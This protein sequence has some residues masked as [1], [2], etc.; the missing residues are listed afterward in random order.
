VHINHGHLRHPQDGTDPELVRSWF[1]KRP[2]FH[3]H[4]TPTHGSWLSIV[5]RRFAEPTMK[6]IRG[7]TFRSVPQLAAAVQVFIE[8][9]YAN[10]KP[11]VWPK[12][13]EA[14]LARSPDSFSE[15]STPNTAPHVS[16]L[17]H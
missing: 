9:H 1:A 8:A 15:P 3:V 7:S 4:F 12:T 14:I 2:R 13:A 17:T 16:R 6:H 5:E 11:F 10:P